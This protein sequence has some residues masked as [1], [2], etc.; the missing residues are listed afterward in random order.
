MGFVFVFDLDQT[1]A[2]DYVEG[3][4]DPPYD[5]IQLNEF[6]I[7]NIITPLHTDDARSRGITDAIVLYTNNGNYEYIKAVEQKISQTYIPGF[8]F[9]YIM[10]R[11]DP[12]RE[13]KMASAPKVLDDVYTIVEEIGIPRANLQNR[14]IF[15]DDQMH[16]LADEIPSSNF[17][18][19]SPPFSKETSLMDQ[20]NY[21]T[22]YR[23][24]DEINNK[25][26]A[27]APRMPGNLSSSSFYSNNLSIGGGRRR[28]R[29]RTAY[30]KKFRT[31][32]LL[33]TRKLRRRL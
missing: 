30:R 7:E 3:P 25:P 13:Y 27:Y 2:G 23:I 12:L 29:G 4:Y 1:V 6:L 32:K 5:S 26:T 16:Y 10:W 31:R 8:Q 22:V 9:D 24:I 14:V 21:S 28:R 33:R 17:I 19:I 18:R 15:F 11:N 20:T